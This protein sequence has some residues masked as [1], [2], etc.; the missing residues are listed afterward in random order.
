MPPAG[1]RGEHLAI[2][3]RYQQNGHT[4]EGHRLSFW[5]PTWPGGRRQ[6][7]QRLEQFPVGQPVAVF[8]DPNDA[9]NSALDRRL[10]GGPLF[11]ALLLTPF[12]LVMVGGWVWLRRR[13]RGLL[14]RLIHVDGR[15]WIVRRALGDPI[16]T[17]VIVAGVVSLS[18]IL[19]TTLGQWQESLPGLA[20][21]WVVLLVVSVIAMWHARR[22]RYFESPRLICDDVTGRVTWLGNE[23][24]DTGEWLAAAQWRRT[25]L[26]DEVPLDSSLESPSGYA[27]RLVFGTPT[28]SEETRTVLVTENALEAATLS[29]WLDDWFRSQTSAALAVPVRAAEIP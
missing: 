18:E 20:V 6:M 13:G 1:P 23:S 14:G 17:G 10:G 22:T 2:S 9:A 5:N 8:V 26:D 7:E 11:L 21:L 12:N 27:V 15:Q 24:S 3:Y 25:E 19:L 28:G 29:E 4:L 16:L